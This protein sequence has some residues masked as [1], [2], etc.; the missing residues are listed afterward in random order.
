MLRTLQ[1]I[2]VAVLLFLL[3]LRQPFHGM[4]Y[5]AGSTVVSALHANGY[6][7]FSSLR[8]IPGVV[9]VPETEYLL[10][11]QRRFMSMVYD[12]LGRHGGPAFIHEASEA[13]FIEIF[14]DQIYVEDFY[15]GENIVIIYTLDE[16][17]MEMAY[18][19]FVDMVQ[20]VFMSEEGRMSPKVHD[21]ESVL[22]LVDNALRILEDPLDNRMEIFRRNIGR[23]LDDAV[24]HTEKIGDIRIV[25]CVGSDRVML[26]RGAVIDRFTLFTVIRSFIPVSRDLAGSDTT[27]FIS[28]SDRRV[29]A[30]GWSG[31]EDAPVVFFLLF[32]LCDMRQL[33][34]HR[35]SIQSRLSER[36]FEAI[37]QCRIELLVP[38]AG[39]RSCE[40]ICVLR[41]GDEH[42][43]RRRD[44]IWR[45]LRK[46]EVP[47][48]KDEQFG[49]C[50]FEDLLSLSER[51]FC[52]G[53]VL[54]KLTEENLSGAIGVYIREQGVSGFPEWLRAFRDLKYLGLGYNPIRSVPDWIGDF[55]DLESLCISAARLAVLPA[56]IGRLLQLR[57]LELIDNE[58]A[59]LPST[60]VNCGK[61]ETLNLLK[62]RLTE[63]PEDIGNLTHLRSL[64]INSNRLKT[65][66]QSLSGC[67][68]LLYCL[69]SDNLLAE[70]PEDIGQLTSLQVLLLEHNHLTRLPESIGRCRGLKCLLLG[71]N[72]L[73]DL[74]VSFRELR[75]LEVLRL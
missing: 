3:L 22:Q 18:E 68:E 41:T 8:P 64:T 74:P 43:N 63:L 60:I 66:P 71:N 36:V 17:R 4:T 26:T 34:L 69:A 12:M 65:L 70:L 55:G 73:L 33:D 27:E 53:I 37:S 39:V 48:G 7:V 56:S 11:I 75:S 67:T 10:P 23:R 30:S 46:I 58:L 19:E 52:G 32:R 40:N 38:P 54:P 49:W 47:D 20:V 50:Y 21:V 31:G 57:R 2:F 16:Q 6:T 35:C 28:L 5:V 62:N 1:S 59:R 72:N 14:A 29:T 13:V 15:Y 44:Q 42:E 51:E 45:W 24:R 25:A 9:E 61:L